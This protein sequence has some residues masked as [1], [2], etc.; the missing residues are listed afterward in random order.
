MLRLARWLSTSPA[1]SPSTLSK[2]D[3]IL[4]AGVDVR[5]ADRLRLQ[6]AVALRAG[7]TA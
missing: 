6:V 5:P 7:G 3:E 2:D 1:P 4:A